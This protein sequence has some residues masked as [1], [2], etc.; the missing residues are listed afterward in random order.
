MD[1]SL[2]SCSPPIIFLSSNPGGIT[3][4]E[5]IG[6][7][8]N[9]NRIPSG[10]PDVLSHQRAR[11]ANRIVAVLRASH[12]AIGTILGMKS[13]GR[14]PTF[15]KMT[16][17]EQVRSIVAEIAGDTAAAERVELVLPETGVCSPS[18]HGL[19]RYRPMLRR[20]GPSR[21]DACCK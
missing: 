21:A 15:L 16:G 13:Y 17:Y 9:A 10:M 11:Y 4:V 19:R 12:P 5:A 3:G 8:E 1:G 6:E 18:S 7:L 20:T 14:A 2:A